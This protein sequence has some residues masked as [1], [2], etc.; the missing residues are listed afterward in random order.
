MKL[1]ADIAKRVKELDQ[2]EWNFQLKQQQ[3]DVDLQKASI[4][5]IRD[6]GVAY[7]EHQQ[8]VTYN[9]RTWW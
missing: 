5:A 4:K 9:I 2:R 7:G 3:D 8:P 1:S 6:I